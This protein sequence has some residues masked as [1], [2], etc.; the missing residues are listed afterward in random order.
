MINLNEVIQ[1]LKKNYPN[2]KGE[3]VTAVKNGGELTG[4]SVTFRENVSAVYHPNSSETDNDKVINEI[5]AMIG[6]MRGAC[7]L[8]EIHLPASFSEV[9]DKLS[10]G[11]MNESF[12]EILKAH[13]IIT[14]RGEDRI[15]YPVV[16]L[17]D[18]RS[19][20]VTKNILKL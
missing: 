9:K 5:L 8:D 13:H 11:V 15:L 3:I 16:V 7:P 2:L 18:S 19:F 10:I 12:K 20:K 6:K 14:R 4:I 1:Y 17:N